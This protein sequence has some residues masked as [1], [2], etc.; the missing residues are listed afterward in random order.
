[1]RI[2]VVGTNN[3]NMYSGGRYHALIMA[4]AMARAGMEVSFITNKKPKFFDDLDPLAPGQVKYYFTKNFKADMPTEQFDFVILIPTGI[5]QPNFYEAVFE[6]T[7][8][9]RARLALV[10]FESGNWF[11]EVSPAPRDLRLWDY[12]QRSIMNGGLVLSSLRISQDYAKSF[13][14][15]PKGEDVRF[16]VCG[17]PINS[18]AAYRHLKTPKD[19]SV[20]TFVRSSDP[21]KG[22]EDL[23]NLP[24]KV[25]SGRTLRVIAG[26]PIEPKFATRLKSH[27]SRANVNVEF[28]NAISDS[29]KFRL[30]GLAKAVLFP[31][32]F[33]GFGYPPIEAA[34]MGA[35]PVCYNLPVLQET[36]GSLVNMA[37][38][39]DLKTL[40]AC[41]EAALS[42]PER[43]EELH[44]GVKGLVDIDSVGTRLTDVLLRSI[45]TVPPLP[46]R[47][48]QGAVGP[49]NWEEADPKHDTVPPLPA[50]LNSYVATEDN[51]YH[52]EVEV[53]SRTADV[54]LEFDA[55]EEATN[56]TVSDV[57]LRDAG[58]IKGWKRIQIIG[59]LSA[60]PEPDQSLWFRLKDSSGALASETEIR[61]TAPGQE[62]ENDLELV[63]FW[64][65]GDET[66]ARFRTAPD[67]DRIMYSLDGEKWDE[68]GVE[69][70][71]AMLTLK[72]VRPQSINVTLIAFA[73][74]ESRQY[75]KGCLPVA[76][77][78]KDWN[79]P[80]HNS[81][82]ILPISSL[83]DRYWFRGILRRP[84]TGHAGV[85]VCDK[86]PDTHVPAKGDIVK[87]ASGRLLPVSNVI[88][89]GDRINLEF[90]VAINP[91]T[92][93]YPNQVSLV[94]KAD[95]SAEPVSVGRLWQDGYWSGA[96]NIGDRCCL[97]NGHYVEHVSENDVA[98]SA[99]DATGQEIEIG[100]ITKTHDGLFIW[101]KSPIA[102]RRDGLPPVELVK[103]S[104]ENGLEISS[105]EL[106]LAL[107]PDSEYWSAAAEDSRVLTLVPNA[108]IEPGDVI[109]INDNA[110]RLIHRVEVT[111]SA[112]YCALDYALP[113][114]IGSLRFATLR[115]RVSLADRQLKY[116]SKVQSPGIGPVT[117]LG[118]QYRLTQKPE[119]KPPVVERERV[120]F[121]SIVPPFP[122]DQGNR[123][124]TRNF[125]SHLISKGFD[126]DLVLVGAMRPE[127]LTK[128]YGDR[129]RVFS[130]NFP[131][132]EKESSAAARRQ[133]LKELNK[134]DPAEMEAETFVALKQKAS[135]YH[136][137]FIVPDPIVHIAKSLY[138]STEYHSIVCNYPHM[139]RVASEL[140]EIRP[141][142]PVT[143]VTHDAL[144][145]LP[146]DFEGE[147]IDTVYRLC[148]RELEREVLDEIPGAVILAISESEVEYFKEIG[149]SN[150]VELCEYDGQK[151]CSRFVVPKTAFRSQR[152]LFH[153]SANPMNV[154]AIKWF[155]KYCWEEIRTAVP[156][157]TLVICGG[158]SKIIPNDT[159]N[160]E[161]HGIVDR[162]RLMEIL[163]TSSVA[164][165]P[166]LAGTGL[167]IKTVEAV[168]AG[169][170][171][172]CLP[173]AVEGLEAV[174]DQF[175]R[176]ETEPFGFSN[177]CI[178]LLTD[179]AAWTDL[180]AS[181]LRIAEE[182]FS[183]Q[184]IYGAVDDAMSWNDGIA[185]REIERLKPLNSRKLPPLDTIFGDLPSALQDDALAASECIARGDHHSAQTHLTRI[186]AAPG[187][188]LTIVLLHASREAMDVNNFQGAYHFAAMAYAND[189]GNPIALTLLGRAAHAVGLDDVARDVWTQTCLIAPANRLSADLAREFGLEA[190]IAQADS[191]QPR[192]LRVALDEQS[193]I[194]SLL[195]ENANLGIGWSWMEDW[196]TWNNGEYARLDLEFPAT[197]ANLDLILMGEFHGSSL[198]GSQRMTVKVDGMDCGQ[199]GTDTPHTDT[200]VRVRLPASPGAA[201]RNNFRV[202]LL[203]DAPAP[204]RDEDGYVKDA[205][206]LAFALKSLKLEQV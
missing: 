73:G 9:A 63:G 32:R 21:H 25:L 130:W 161:I 83:S 18:P 107:L 142:P 147:P 113:E 76:G 6:F 167:K 181:S 170:P 126:V 99:V 75:Y 141:L 40:S 95:T 85:I 139:I 128:L 111:E 118:H 203:F 119:H 80:E 96:G 28:H 206:L 104:K 204:L 41:L 127:H 163:G 71:T 137:Y 11:N 45:E 105:T 102:V 197:N 160:T 49:F 94:G 166:T 190:E 27:F 15:S 68:I 84:T 38:V 186:A 93:G 131:D 33:E 168:C 13:Y 157:A 174:C 154:V 10:N 144:S 24:P 176:L 55:G 196:G 150:P 46:R 182:R 66:K 151:E 193:Y 7:R 129:V 67:I 192:P 3:D 200:E 201:L 175:C 89:K 158:I 20:V 112:V 42:W 43:R 17:P 199:F 2:A 194:K 54:T 132:W 140:S 155:L 171:S 146:Q 23:L 98:L 148:T 59:Q 39:G 97:L 134:A 12:W 44:K 35:E 169:L 188:N 120:M 22:G 149:V 101:C 16:E 79:R 78:V 183:E 177:A 51:T 61:L 153:A 57:V 4:Y 56:L 117:S 180:R 52:F 65:L 195:P 121:I 159:P 202:E 100:S 189:P 37:P 145:R 123:I 152:I 62:N 36:V 34:F 133:I 138:R 30:I 198:D 106:A 77:A 125:I 108:N 184:A 109:V 26:G 58:N 14:Q 1:M 47:V 116:S 179:K 64:D 53:C 19:G 172:V 122:A 136:P 165:N 74:S 87:L 81:S 205:R 124:V 103:A 8:T 90:I 191:W 173:K 187:G 5:F 110:L 91:E 178:E 31:S 82:G 70:E 48:G 86:L 143:V 162:D 50:M 29:E 60:E 156:K 92:E 72:G 185:T 164:I 114:T 115:E 69:D 135:L 88:D